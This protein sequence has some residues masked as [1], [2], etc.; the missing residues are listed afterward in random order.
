MK[1]TR[2]LTK[3]LGGPCPRCGSIRV[4]MDLAAPMNLLAIPG[5]FVVEML[6]ALIWIGGI[7]EAIPV[8][9]KCGMCRLKYR[10]SDV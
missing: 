10:L 7:S 5:Y 4:G 9:M 3:P 2:E 8:R 1:W 6:T